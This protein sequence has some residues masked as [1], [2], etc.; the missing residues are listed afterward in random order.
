MY[1]AIFLFY[2]I[3]AQPKGVWRERAK[4][5]PVKDIKNSLIIKT[6]YTDN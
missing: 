2:T 3:L 6:N 5:N 1:S 4:F